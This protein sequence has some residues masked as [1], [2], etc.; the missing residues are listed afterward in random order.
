[1]AEIWLWSIWIMRHSIP[2]PPAHYLAPANSPDRR[3]KSGS[4]RKP[5]ASSL[6]PPSTQFLCS[7]TLMSLTCFLSTWCILA[8]IPL[9]LAHKIECPFSISFKFRYAKIWAIFHYA[10][11]GPYCEEWGRTLIISGHN[12]D[13]R[14]KGLEVVKHTSVMNLDFPFLKMEALWG[15]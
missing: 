15:F 5:R 1:M 9:H 12:E 3:K 2:P 4:R 11:F 7:Q 14:S 8:K 6:L 10:T 13:F